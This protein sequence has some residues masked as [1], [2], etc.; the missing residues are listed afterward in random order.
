MAACRPPLL[1]QVGGPAIRPSVGAY[2]SPTSAVVLRRRKPLGPALAATSS[3]APLY[4]EQQRKE[5]MA[6]LPVGAP[7]QEAT[8]MAGPKAK[9]TPP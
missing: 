2:I 1:A 7:L 4:A 3:S 8:L 6:C 9:P 5:A